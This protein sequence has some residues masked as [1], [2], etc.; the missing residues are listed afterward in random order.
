[1]TYQS[2]IARYLFKF[3]PLHIL[4]AVLMR[5]MCIFTGLPILIAPYMLTR[6]VY[7]RY[8]GPMRTATIARTKSFW[9]SKIGVAPPTSDNEVADELSAFLIKCG[10]DP[11]Q[12][13][14]SVCWSMFGTPLVIL[15][16]LPSI[17]DVLVDAQQRKNRNRKGAAERGQL[18]NKIQN[19][20]FGGKNI[21]NTVGEVRAL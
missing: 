1:M 2:N 6:W 15:N 12:Q 8:F 14:W 10:Q 11:K 18:I 17:K 9:I 4:D 7:Y 13:P 5:K 20:V 16:S 3:L 21:N 19:I